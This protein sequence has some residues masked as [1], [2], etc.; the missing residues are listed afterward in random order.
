M[1]GRVRQ[2]G[3]DL[4]YG[5]AR[6]MSVWGRSTPAKLPRPAVVALFVTA[7]LVRY[8]GLDLPYY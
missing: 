3:L 8:R 2:G 6:S 1:A 7:G 5:Q 4:P